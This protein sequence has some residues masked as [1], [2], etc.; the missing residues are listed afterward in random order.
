VRARSCFEVA[1]QDMDRPAR[2]AAQRVDAQVREYP[3]IA[4][5]IAAGVGALLGI[6]LGR[7]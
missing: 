1:T 6:L 5:G 4:V 7:R 2:E 3:W